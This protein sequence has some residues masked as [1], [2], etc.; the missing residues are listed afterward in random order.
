MKLRTKIVL[1]TGLLVSMLIG[2]L[3]IYLNSY[4]Y[5]YFKSQTLKYLYTL[6]EL[7]DASFDAFTAR[8]KVRV[9]DWASD[10][11][12]RDTTEKITASLNPSEKE[13][14][15]QELSLYLRDKK[16]I[17]DPS[18]IMA[19]VL[20]KNGAVVA[21]SRTSRIGQDE[22]REKNKFP[23]AIKGGFGEAFVNN[24]VFEKD[25]DP[26]RP[27]I[28]IST[29]IFSLQE[30]NSRPVLLDAVLLVHFVNTE[31][32][33]DSLSG[34]RQESKAKKKEVLFESSKT[35]DV[36]LVNNE[37]FMIT[38]ARYKPDTVLRQKVETQ[39]VRAC[40]EKGHD[41]SGEYVNYSGET[42][43]GVGE[44]IE[45]GNTIII[46]MVKSEAILPIVTVIY[47]IIISGVTTV[48]LTLL[49]I[50]IL[51]LLSFRNFVLLGNQIREIAKTKQ[52]QRRITIKTKDEVGQVA[53]DFN[54]LLDSLNN[55]EK[56]LRQ[57]K[58]SMEKKVVERT[59]E[60][61]E[62]QARLTA[63][64]KGLSLGFIMADNNNNII[65]TNP[66]I[67]KILGRGDITI[68]WITKQFAG[69]FDLLE[70]CRKCREEKT[71]ID[72]KDVEYGSKFLRIFLAP[73]VMIRDHEEIIGM[74]ILMEDITEAKILDRSRDEFFSIA[75]HELRTPLTAIRGN[76][77]LIKQYYWDSLADE[78]LKEMI[79]D[80]HSSSIRLIEIV[81]DF[82]DM[83]RLELGKIEFKKE[84]T[85][86][87][88]VIQSVIKE[89]QTTGSIKILY[90]KFN[91]PKN[92][93][94]KVLTDA[95]RL[96]QILINLIG[97]AIKFTEKGGVTLDITSD[98]KFVKV[99]VTDTGKGIPAES[100]RLLFR[101]FQ[102]GENNI[103]TRDN[104]QGTGL[105]L[106]ISKLMVEGMGGQISL[107]KSEAGK[108]TTFSFT[109]PVMTA[110]KEQTKVSEKAEFIEPMTETKIRMS[111]GK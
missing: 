106:Y 101:K 46:E 100:Q 105:G 82:L 34:S 61:A 73:V 40:L 7:S 92:P 68:D 63:S 19:E 13:K 45:D 89:Y 31:E 5:G 81:N 58:E 77:S 4:F 69:K 91:P 35:L 54:V 24:V 88:E 20:D 1:L 32:I 30:I 70:N 99:Y 50:L 47:R 15:S 56:D 42:V 109:M 10:G 79:D 21:S 26:N 41:F 76:T 25:E 17:F 6:V 29:R 59:R 38:P 107:E 37:G 72:I 48:V 98:E 16:I 65:M 43:W 95:D 84:Q 2:G 85:D 36:Y 86:I 102:Q 90:L 53:A 12:I 83:S 52:F 60:L 9:V 57:E 111:Q 64:I 94:P 11:Y 55:Y 62:E 18:V 108:G 28:H 8:L 23:E 110:M 49:G 27:M 33:K 97:N 71:T 66:A 74:V 67:E 39:P 44:C 104:T 96:K 103:L 22:S 87:K 14:L 80:I 93:V 51:S 3:V 75:S 78:D